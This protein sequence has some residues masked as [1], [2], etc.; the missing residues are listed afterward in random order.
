MGIDISSTVV[1]WFVIGIIFFLVELA[2]PGFILFFFGIGAV[3][4]SILLA[5]GIIDSIFAQVVV[6]IISSLLS[7]TLFRLIWKR[8]FRG[9]VGHERKPGE[10]I[11]EVKGKKALVVEDIEPGKL[12]GQ[13]ELFGTVWEAESDFFIKKGDVVEILDR[14]NLLLKVKPLD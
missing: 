7:L 11:D 2:V 10:S 12:G 9:D 14:K 1:L 13:V 3:V 5:F 8:D 4:T 6:F